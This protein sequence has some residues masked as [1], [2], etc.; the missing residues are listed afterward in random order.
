MK[1]EAP[2]EVPIRLFLTA[3][4]ECG[5]FPDRQ[6]RSLVLDPDSPWLAEIYPNAIDHGFRRSSQRIYRPHCANC[7][8]CTPTRIV[9]ERF[10]PDRSQRRCSARNADLTVHVAPAE[11]SEERFTLYARYLAARHGDSPMAD[12]SREEFEG[13]LLGG[14]SRTVFIELRE[15][16]R[17]VAAAA[18]DELPQGLSAVYT[19]FD[20]DLAA[21]GLGTCAIL[22][23]IALAS[24]RGLPYLYLGYWIDGHPKMDYKRR[25]AALQVLRDGHWQDLE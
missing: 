20:P 13:F 17:L 25:F 18:T 9:L 23:Q 12:P 4:H 5:Y 8:A 2:V 11:F 15:Q 21:R 22:T 7:N 19:F 24:R 3:P 10:R 16:G 6:A 1:M 14:W